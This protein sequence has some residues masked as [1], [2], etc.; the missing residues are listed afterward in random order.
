MAKFQY[1][2]QP[3]KHQKECLIK[4][5]TLVGYGL[6]WEP[7][8]GKTFPMIANFCWLLE[9]EPRLVDTLLVVAPNGVQRNWITD[10]I[11]THMPDR[12]ASKI[13][14]LIWKSTKLLTQK[15]RKQVEET[16]KHD[17]PIVVVVN[18]ESV[19]RKKFKQFAA[20]LLR[21]KVFM[22]LDESHRIKSTNSHVKKTLIALG[23]YA[24]YRRILTGT[25]LEKPE[26]I[27]TQIRFIDPD[28]WGKKG[29]RTPTEFRL[30]YCIFRKGSTCKP[31]RRP[32]RTGM[33][34]IEFATPV[35]AKNL[36]ELQGYVSEVAHRLTKDDAGLDLPPKLYSKRYCELSPEQNRVYSELKNKYKTLLQ[37]G[38]L[39]KAELPIVRLLRLQQVAAGY[40]AIESDQ[41]VQMIEP[42]VNNR[43]AM[44]VEEILR[45]LPHQAIV[46]SRFN[47]D[48]DQLMAAL[49][50]E[51]VRYDGQVKEEQRAVNKLRFQNGDAKYFVGKI[52]SGGTGL[53]LIQAKTMVYYENYFS[54]IPRLQADDR[55]HRV[56]QTVPVNIIDIICENTVDEYIVDKLRAKFDIATQVTGDAERVWL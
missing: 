15:Y 16:L 19:I 4:S 51:A 8:C 47:A 28:F 55:F 6:F 14:T 41:P 21:R 53:T 49:G 50:S 1:K 32:G 45:P 23:A 27:Y 39:L 11:P 37:S 25:P 13:K 42:G 54:L 18:Y 24:K 29:F 7:G 43:L 12:H 56:G 36:D 3:L 2:T 34:V 30:R 48:I 40:V 44:C 10:E 5:A 9:Q 20:R 31:D 46:W 22:V 26:D 38:D 35:G 52:T 33:R 17:G